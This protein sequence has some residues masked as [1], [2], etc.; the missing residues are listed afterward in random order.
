M[1]EDGL[2]AINT[3]KDDIGGHV[4]SVPCKPKRCLELLHECDIII[5]V[6]RAVV[7]AQSISDAF[8][9]VMLLKVIRFHL[10][11]NDFFNLLPF[12]ADLIF[13]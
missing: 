10:D 1:N 8:P 3:T 5:K 11:V 13:F 12:G 2:N 4:M 7:V 9:V 6:Q